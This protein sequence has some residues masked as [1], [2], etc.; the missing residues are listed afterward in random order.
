M[1]W[2]F[3]SIYSLTCVVQEHYVETPSAVKSINLLL[4]MSILLASLAF[5]DVSMKTFT[6]IQHTGLTICFPFSFSHW[7]QT[8]FEANYC[9]WNSAIWGWES[10]LKGKC[11]RE[12]V[13]LHKFLTSQLD[14]DKWPV[15]SSGEVKNLWNLSPSFINFNIV[16]SQIWSCSFSWLIIII[17]IIIT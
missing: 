11:T 13:K 14:G 6:N 1:L 15:P 2:I 8:N 16:M 5:R 9:L 3:Y 10:K 17:I 12:R 4:N 7:L